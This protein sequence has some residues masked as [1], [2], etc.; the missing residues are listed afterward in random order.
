MKYILRIYPRFWKNPK[1]FIF[2]FSFPLSFNGKN[3][4]PIFIFVFS[5]KF[6][7]CFVFFKNKTLFFPPNKMRFS[8]QVQDEPKMFSILFPRQKKPQG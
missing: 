5:P 3:L 4:W 8:V 1:N 6:P 2:S 7:E